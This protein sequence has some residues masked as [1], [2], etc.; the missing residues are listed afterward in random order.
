MNN[1]ERLD[2]MYLTNRQTFFKGWVE[3]INDTEGQII[4]DKEAHPNFKDGGT[5]PAG[6]ILVPYRMKAR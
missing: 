2:M 3:P 4:I 6:Y 1:K 5:L